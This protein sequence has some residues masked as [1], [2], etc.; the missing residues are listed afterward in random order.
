MIKAYIF[1]HYVVGKLWMNWCICKYDYDHIK[2]SSIQDVLR[3]RKKKTKKKKVPWWLDTFIYPESIKDV[4]YFI[5][6]F[7]EEESPIVVV[8]S[9]NSLQYEIIGLLWNPLQKHNYCHCSNFKYCIIFQSNSLSVLW[10]SCCKSP[11][12]IRQFTRW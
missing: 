1:K 8:C 9:S 7:I 4:I 6:H 5:F 10:Q 12:M 3:D 2:N 11:K